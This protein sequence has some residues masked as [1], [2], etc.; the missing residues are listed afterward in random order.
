MIKPEI[1][2]P[3]GAAPHWRRIVVVGTTGS[4]KTTLA[5][6]LA[7]RL[8]LPHVELDALYWDPD[9]TPAPTEVFRER[10][11]HALAVDACVVDG[12]YQAVRDIIWRRAEMVV[13][14]DYS[15]PVI[16]RRLA[17]RT[18][19]RLLT[20]EE[21]WNGNHER[22]RDHFLSRDSL[23]LWAL[24]TY[25]RRRREFPVLLKRPEYAHLQVVRL[26]SPGA[27]Q[28]WLAGLPA[29]PAPEPAGERG[30]R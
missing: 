5:R 24:Q 12:N 1:A 17:G 15:L 19:R 30:R 9:W 14:L 10:T 21:L 25:R 27:A 11:A 22:W 26:R 7:G 2:D 6:R 16:M 8:G 23:F 18:F 3:P 4:G 28:R 13:W 29:S 20:R